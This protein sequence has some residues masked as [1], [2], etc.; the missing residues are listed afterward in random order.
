MPKG[1]EKVYARDKLHD[2]AKNKSTETM[3]AINQELGKRICKVR[4]GSRDGKTVETSLMPQ[5]KHEVPIG[6]RNQQSS[7]IVIG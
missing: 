5:K 4:E 1:P 3:F 7:Q 2:R 6:V